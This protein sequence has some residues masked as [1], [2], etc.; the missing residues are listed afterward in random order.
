M[1]NPAVPIVP[2]PLPDPGGPEEPDPNADPERDPRR[3]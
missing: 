1:T 2:V 3:D